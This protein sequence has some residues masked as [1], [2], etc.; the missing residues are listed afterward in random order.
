MAMPE[1]AWGIKFPALPTNATHMIQ[2]R[3][4]TAWIIDSADMI[5]LT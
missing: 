4:I 1:D 5:N 3:E 2:E